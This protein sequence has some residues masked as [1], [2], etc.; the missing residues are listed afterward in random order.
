MKSTGLIAYAAGI[1]TFYLIAQYMNLRKDELP[2]PNLPQIFAHLGTFLSFVLIIIEMQ[3]YWISV[4]WSILALIVMIAGFAT[5][6]KYLRMQGLLIFTITILKVFIYDTRNLETIFRTVSYIV[7]GAI[8]LL[9]SLI[10]S[11]YKDKLK[12]IL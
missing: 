2:S 8:L 11:K 1:I 5:S 9:V 3:N 10:Y 6:K 4:G 7:L 12:E